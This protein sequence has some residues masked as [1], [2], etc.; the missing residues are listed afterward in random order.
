MFYIIKDSTAEELP[1]N[2]PNNQL[3]PFTFEYLAYNIETNQNIDFPGIIA[4]LSAQFS[5]NNP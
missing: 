5:L 4:N 3:Q 1:L 2:Y